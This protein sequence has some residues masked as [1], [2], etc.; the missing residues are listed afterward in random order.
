MDQKGYLLIHN[1]WN[2]WR[3]SIHNIHVV[4]T[5]ALSYQNKSPEKCHLNVE[6]EGKRKYLEVWLQQR[7]HFSPF[8]ISIDD[9][10]SVEVE[11]TLKFLAR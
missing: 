4:N 3:D 7:H 6:K 1:L 11:E 9:L 5:N 2:I 10:I 8:V